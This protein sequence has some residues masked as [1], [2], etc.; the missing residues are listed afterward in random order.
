MIDGSVLG[1]GMIGFTMVVTAA[2]VGYTVGEAILA[3]L[4]KRKEQRDEPE[5]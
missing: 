2:V 5:E 4:R 1:W 3:Y